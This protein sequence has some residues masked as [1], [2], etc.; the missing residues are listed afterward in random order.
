MTA[1]LLKNFIDGRDLLFG[2]LA[3]AKV[4]SGGDGRK[5]GMVPEAS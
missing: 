1:L 5:Y 3:S 2:I 4:Q